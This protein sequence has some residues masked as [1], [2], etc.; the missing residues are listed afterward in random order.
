[1]PYRN[2][3]DAAH[4]LIESLKRQLEERPEPPEEEEKVKCKH[5]GN[6]DQPAIWG[7]SILLAILCAFI[8]FIWITAG[9]HGDLG[10]CY[11][12]ATGHYVDDNWVN[13]YR[14]SQEINWGSD[15]SVG[16]FDTLAEAKSAA[17]MLGCPLVH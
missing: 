13:Q 7:G 5:C 11:I 16:V 9:T 2:E 15:N 17:D 3:L 12:E 6:W 1:M 4:A 10:N 8:A 14:L